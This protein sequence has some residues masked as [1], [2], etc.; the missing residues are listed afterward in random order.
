MAWVNETHPDNRGA[1]WAVAASRWGSPASFNSA[2]TLLNGA[3]ADDIFDPERDPALDSFRVAAGGGDTTAP[4]ATW[5]RVDFGGGRVIT[6]MR[7]R[8]GEST[9][10]PAT[11]GS[12]NIRYK[13]C[14]RVLVQGSFNA[15]TWYT[16]GSFYVPLV[17]RTVFGVDSHEILLNNAEPYRYYR[18]NWAMD[19]SSPGCGSMVGLD[20]YSGTFISEHEESDFVYSPHT[21]ASTPVS[22]LSYTSGYPPENVLNLSLATQFRNSNDNTYIKFDIGDLYIVNMIKLLSGLRTQSNG[23]FNVNVYGSV[24]GS[25]YDKLHPGSIFIN[26][27]ITNGIMNIDLR[28]LNY[29]EYRH[30]LL[31][32]ARVSEGNVVIL[33]GVE[34]GHTGR[35]VVMRETLPAR[36]VS[37]SSTYPMAICNR[38]PLGCSGLSGAVT[39]GEE[40]E[41]LWGNRV[42]REALTASGVTGII[43]GEYDFEI[44]DFYVEREISV[45]GHAAPIGV[46]SKPVRDMVG[47]A[48]F[49]RQCNGAITIR[50]SLEGSVG[51]FALMDAADRSRYE[52]EGHCGWVG[53]V[54]LAKRAWSLIPLREVSG[55]A[56]SGNLARG[57]TKNLV[58]TPLTMAAATG[59]LSRNLEWSFTLDGTSIH[60][61]TATGEATHA[62]R[63]MVALATVVIVGE[64]SVQ[65]PARTYSGACTVRQVSKGKMELPMAKVSGMAM[66]P[67]SATALH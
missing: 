53:D 28:G 23:T 1:G 39:S 54:L 32:F 15:S 65:L 22:A 40:S 8:Y 36:Y 55:K 4:T 50:H 11:D 34:L 38:E 44:E 41:E 56:T 62:V 52:M 6:K 58:R 33:S 37:V 35:W 13:R 61:V 42:T 5:L 67:I 27:F 18:F 49:G 51:E 63:L 9:S 46:M 21:N 10:W 43:A 26:P 48:G 30:Y 66:V 60:P 47:L 7:V 19:Y 29:T 64:A 57:S 17:S 2:F 3:S 59:A 45:L 24:S 20:L 25:S 31:D 14:N 12:W 16:V